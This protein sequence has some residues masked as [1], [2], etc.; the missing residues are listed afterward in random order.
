VLG[1]FHKAVEYILYLYWP[2]SEPL[3]G[4][5]RTLR[6]RGTHRKTTDQDDDT[7][8][9]SPNEN[10]LL[11]GG[12]AIGNSQVQIIFASVNCTALCIIF[13]IVYRVLASST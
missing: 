4:T 12:L 2:P 9:H 13:I 10:N 11:P 1:D 3:A 5:P 8:W 6:F 7:A